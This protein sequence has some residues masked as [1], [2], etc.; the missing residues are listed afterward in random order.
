MSV[1]VVKSN[2]CR[3]DTGAIP[4]ELSI[5]VA[6][7]RDIV[8]IGRG[9]IRA[10]VSSGTSV[11]FRTPQCLMRFRGKTLMTGPDGLFRVVGCG[12]NP[13]FEIGPLG[14][15]AFSAGL[16]AP[17]T[18]M[19]CPVECT[20]TGMI[21]ETNQVRLTP[22]PGG[23]LANRIRTRVKVD[24]YESRNDAVP[25]GRYSLIHVDTGPQYPFGSYVFERH[26]NG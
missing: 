7:S 14:K 26:V 5:G 6:V 12:C 24:R 9:R 4:A 10:S 19:C 3:L 15:I 17:R 2:H 22:F 11:W 8:E 16:I 1:L 21:L 20:A 13:E 18:D 25:R 23:A